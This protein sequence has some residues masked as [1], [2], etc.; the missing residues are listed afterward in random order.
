MKS[1][2]FDFDPE[3]ATV[4]QWK[5]VR[6]M[7]TD[8]EQ[9]ELCELWLMMADAFGFAEDSILL[10]QVEDLIHSHSKWGNN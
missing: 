7:L 8:P 6:G 10:P 5:K 2:Q 4:A 3:T 1:K 9:E